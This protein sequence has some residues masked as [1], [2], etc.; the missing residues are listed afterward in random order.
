M[1][2]V[3]VFGSGFVGSVIARALSAREGVEVDVLDI[4]THPALARRD[5]EA[6]AVV[7]AAVE[8]SDVVVN[9]SGRL[10]G[11]DEEM[12]DANVAWPEWLAEQIESTGVRFV[13]LG[14]AAEYG[15]PGSAEPVA[16]TAAVD[17]RGIYG[18]SKW[19]G[20][21]AV[22]EARAAGLD[23]VVARGFNLVGPNLA[24]VS[25]LHQFIT[26]ISVLPPEGGEIELWW[27]ETIRDFVLV[28]D[29]AEA[30]ARLALAPAVPD[31]VNLCSQAAISFR[32]IA[33]AIAA[34]QSKAITI[35]SLD[36]PGIPAVVGD[37]T[38]LR[39]LTGLD[40][41]IDA[42]TIAERASI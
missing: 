21:Q 27:P 41:S 40:P 16:E 31:I 19:L 4:P 22:L 2:R 1:Q 28:E 10:R 39:E 15:D 32:E 25:P 34:K 35:R 24:P 12:M 14:S 8:G 29:L 33:E 11:T 26:D 6:A 42:A 9:T 17:P 5:E 20:T 38:R 30:V 36:R 13:H 3:V 18:E 37:N 23:A 7:A